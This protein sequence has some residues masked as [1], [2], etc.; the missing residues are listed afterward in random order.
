MSPSDVT[1]G[2]SDVASI[3]GRSPWAGPHETWARL[4][5]LAPRYSEG[6][7]SNRRGHVL[8]DALLADYGRAT[9]TTVTPG[10]KLD[11]PGI[12]SPRMPWA[13]ARPDGMASNGRGVESKT[14]RTLGEADGWAGEPDDDW[15]EGQVG[16]GLIPEEYECQLAWQSAIIDAPVDLIALGMLTDEIRIYRLERDKAVEKDVVERVRD[17]MERYVWGTPTPPPGADPATLA[18]VYSKPSREWLDPSEDDLEVAARLRAVTEN[19]K[20]LE[21]ESQRLRGL[22]CLSIGNAYGLRGVARWESRKG[23][24]GIDAAKLRREHPEIYARVVT[25]GKPGRRLVP[26]K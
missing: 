20:T 21:A 23:K 11:E 3:L 15:I 5:G 9:E 8:E 19:M 25:T 6:N 16:D 13:H 22:L 10:P 18:L 2:S 4:V 12:V 17:W 14:D 1:V 24:T 26:L 7:R